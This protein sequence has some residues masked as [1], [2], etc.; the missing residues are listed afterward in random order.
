MSTDYNQI[1]QSALEFM[2]AHAAE[3]LSVN[4]IGKNAGYSGSRLQHIFM[5]YTGEAIFTHLIR[6]RIDKAKALL[7]QTGLSISQISLEA[8][9][10][11]HTWFCAVFRK[12]TG[13]SPGEYR[14]RQG[15]SQDGC[16]R[17]GSR[18]DGKTGQ[19][20]YAD[21]FSGDTPGQW[22]E[23][24]DGEWLVKNGILLGSG[25]DHATIALNRP[26]P[27]NFVAAFD[28]L[29]SSIRGPGFSH[30]SLRLLD[31]K[32]PLFYLGAS[33]GLEDAPA[34]FINWY[35]TRVE[36]NTLP[37][38]KKGVWQRL[39][40]SLLDNSIRLSV[41]G[42]VI[43]NF[44]DP[45]PPAYERRCRLGIQ[46][47]YGNIQIRNFAI[48]DKGFLTIT[49]P[50]R[51]GDA[52][53]NMG[54]YSQAAEFY[55]RLLDSGLP[56]GEKEEI[57]YKIG[58][59]RFLQGEYDQA[60]E[61]LE[62]AAKLPDSNFWAQ[63]A[64]IALLETAWH[65]G[66]QEFLFEQIPFLYAKPAFTEKVYS[67][68]KGFCTDLSSR[69]FFEQCLVLQKVLWSRGERGHPTMGDLQ[70]DMGNTL[71]LLNRFEPAITHF[72]EAIESSDPFR[73]SMKINSYF[74]IADCQYH[75]G[76]FDAA[77]QSL[78]EVRKVGSDSATL[79][80][81]MAYH[82]FFLRAQGKFEEALA[83][84][85]A[86]G[87]KYPTVFNWRAFSL[88][89]GSHILCGLNQPTKAREQIV[90][91]TDVYAKEWAL[92]PG[93]KSRFFYPPFL[94]EGNTTQAANILMEDARTPMPEPALQAEYM[95]KA[96]LLY[97]L[98]GQSEKAN[99]VWDEAAMRYPPSQCRF[100]A[101]V[102]NGLRNEDDAVLDELPYPVRTRTELFYLTG[103]LCEKRGDAA[104]GKEWFGKSA[105]ENIA[106]EW[107]GV[108]AAK[109]LEA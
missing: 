82:I 88:L 37:S 105:R 57:E 67:V 13:M 72:R 46:V 51:Q 6:I 10:G 28:C 81:I 65:Q 38:S 54:L 55:L 27:E 15:F 89:T 25:P 98:A 40:F 86:I 50:I 9:F 94:L 22:W 59:S 29:A 107:P 106:G 90:K 96:G 101:F 99:S 95:I 35:N 4:S 62:K 36:S 16:E 66:K 33:M 12:K 24:V 92:V 19:T 7:V 1:I 78:E 58:K 20:G 74:S 2:Q 26:L 80:R 71:I 69:G 61:W 68:A 93:K 75:L 5:T 30:L 21:S 109:K 34:N 41:D 45:F 42:A 102:A 43:L 18:K 14:K 100:W 17:S 77:M 3:D 87:E 103:L 47:W 63:C 76:D 108:L 39:E 84:I 31:R 53:Y 91:A 73:K 49:R 11:S 64:S 23:Q 70:D 85:S 79:A 97:A 52:F 8:G 60:C 44:R 48:R 104:R 56:G 83:T 32:A